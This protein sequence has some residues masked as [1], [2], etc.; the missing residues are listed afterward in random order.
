MTRL[1]VRH[2]PLA[3]LCSVRRHILADSRGSFARLFCAE[4]LAEAGWSGSIAQINHSVSRGRGVIRGLHYQQPPAA[5]MKLVTCVRG[6]VLDVAVDLR[7]GSATLLRVHAERLDADQGAALLIPPGF[8][9]GFQTLSDEVELI[10]CHS[11]PF[12][13]AAERG[14]HPF[15]PLIG[16]AW[17]EP[18]GMMSDRD[19][20]HP[21]LTPAFQGLEI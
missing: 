4:E 21:L 10:Y 15:D 12:D 1:S 16:I 18:V 9:H 20:N 11:H 3:G 7:A 14:V 8:A 5:E 13:P 2:A 6:A 17:P 19:R